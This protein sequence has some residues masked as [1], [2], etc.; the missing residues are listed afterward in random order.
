MAK[1]AYQQARERISAV[2]DATYRMVFTPV[3]IGEGHCFDDTLYG[4]QLRN[5]KYANIPTAVSCPPL[6]PL[7]GPRQRRWLSIGMTG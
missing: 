3:A 2:G 5:P 6:A 1:W 4:E 7:A